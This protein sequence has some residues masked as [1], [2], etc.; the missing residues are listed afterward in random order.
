MFGL[1]LTA[2]EET[3]MTSSHH[4]SELLQDLEVESEQ[5]AES[6]G[7]TELHLSSGS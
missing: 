7:A 1:N 4:F 5:E 3:I 6:Q 2:I